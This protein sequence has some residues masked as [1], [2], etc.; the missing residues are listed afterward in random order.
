MKKQSPPGAANTT[1]RPALAHA[2]A[3]ATA[4]YGGAHRESFDADFYRE[5]TFGLTVSSIGIGTYLGECTDEEDRRYTAA[6]RF[7]FTHGINVVDTAI[8]YR[9]QRAE[10]SVCR[11]LR[12]AVDAG[13]IARD[14]VVVCSKGGYIPLEDE[15]PTSREQYDA[16]VQREF[17]DAGIVSPD[18][19]VAGGHS[20]ASTFL[21]YCIARS[22]QN[23]GVRTIDVYY[24]HNPEQ[25]LASTTPAQLQ[26][27]LRVAFATLEEAVARRD[28]GVY[29]VATWNGLLVPPGAKGHLSLAELVETAREVA[30]DAHHFRAVQLPV[31]LA[32][33]AAVREPTQRLDARE[34]VP[35]LEAAV[36][37]GLTVVASASLMQGQLARGL[38]DPVRALFPRARSDAAR[39]LSFVRAL[40]GVATALVGTREVAHLR[41]NLASAE[42]ADRAERADGAASAEG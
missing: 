37:L 41:E 25:Q 24:L 19:V 15:P 12:Q 23:L 42:R 17:F 9:C 7:A 20:L 10:R 5:T 1:L 35:A 38:P 6:V 32:M 39:A 16:Y 3:P 26:A 31:N 18:D 2:S 34:P 14:Q 21:K 13:E 4:G 40:P 27:R 36:A 8:N 30:G 11:A 29:G 22:R 28:I 33:A